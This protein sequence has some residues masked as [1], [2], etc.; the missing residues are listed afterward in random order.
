MLDKN[1]KY[2]EKYLKI[3]KIKTYHFQFL[4]NNGMF[5]NISFEVLCQE[6]IWAM[7]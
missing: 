5:K 6:K 1:N 2:E 7:F 3:D 4:D